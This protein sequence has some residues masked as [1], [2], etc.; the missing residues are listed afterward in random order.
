[1]PALTKVPFIIF[2]PYDLVKKLFTFLGLNQPELVLRLGIFADIT[3]SVTIFIV[4]F[5]AVS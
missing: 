1:M 2:L 3:L 5:I 4:P